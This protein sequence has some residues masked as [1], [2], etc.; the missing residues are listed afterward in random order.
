MPPLDQSQRYPARH[1][2]QSDCAR[3][4]L[5]YSIHILEIDMHDQEF[6]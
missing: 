2:L 1:G 4:P 5:K 3:A 6:F